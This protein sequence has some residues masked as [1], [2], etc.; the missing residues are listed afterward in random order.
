M[1]YSIPY[2]ISKLVNS[3]KRSPNLSSTDLLNTAY[4]AMFGFIIGDAIGSHLIHKSQNIQD[5][6]TYAL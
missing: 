4:G 3:Y 5:L 2:S 1:N 6:I